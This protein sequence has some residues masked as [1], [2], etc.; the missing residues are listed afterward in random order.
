ME[1]EIYKSIY[2]NFLSCV[3]LNI[4][5]LV[6]EKEVVLNIINKTVQWVVMLKLPL[7]VDKFI[8][9]LK[10]YLYDLVDN[11]IKNNERKINSIIID[12]SDLIVPNEIHDLSANLYKYFNETDNNIICNYL[13]FKKSIKD[14]TQLINFDESYIKNRINKIIIYVKNYYETLEIKNGYKKSA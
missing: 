6:K 4:L 12:S 8:V 10:K 14:I 3:Y 5:S 1:N 9:R 13:V 2:N 7:D 11:H